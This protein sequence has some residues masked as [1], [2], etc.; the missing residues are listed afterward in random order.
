LQLLVNLV[1]GSQLQPKRSLSYSKDASIS[2][3]TCK[4]LTSNTL[5]DIYVA[6]FCYLRILGSNAL[7]SLVNEGRAML[8]I[9][10]HELFIPALVLSLLIL[11]FPNDV[12]GAGT[13]IPMKLKKA[14]KNIA[15]GTVNIDVTTKI[16]LIFKHILP[17]TLGVIVVT[18][19]FTVP[20]A[21]FFE[22]LCWNK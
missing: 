7:G 5:S 1:L 19:M 13:P 4:L 10:P 20:N 14:S 22:A 2:K 9:H 3:E 12:L 18:S 6:P 8:L 16:K 21:I 17:N 11:F 15:L